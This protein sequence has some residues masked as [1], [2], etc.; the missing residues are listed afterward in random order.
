MLSMISFMEAVTTAS[1][2][3]THEQWQLVGRDFDVFFSLI[4]IVVI[5]FFIIIIITLH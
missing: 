5:F 2:D 3:Y 1:Q 4:F